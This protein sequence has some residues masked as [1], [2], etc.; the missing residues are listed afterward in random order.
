MESG[1]YLTALVFAVAILHLITRGVDSYRRHFNALRPNRSKA[2]N[3]RGDWH[4]FFHCSALTGV[5][6]EQAARNGKDKNLSV[7]R[8]KSKA[9]ESRSLLRSNLA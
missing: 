4:L 3:K 1:F 8:E 2:S 7:R 6:Q 5:T 9:K